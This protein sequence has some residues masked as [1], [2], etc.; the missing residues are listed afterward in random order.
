MSYTLLVL[1][2]GIWAMIYGYYAICDSKFFGHICVGYS[3][4]FAVVIIHSLAKM[5]F[6]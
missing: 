6:V 2:I 5:V 3:I 4:A 1:L